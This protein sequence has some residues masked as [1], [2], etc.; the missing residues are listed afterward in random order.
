MIRKSTIEK[1]DT[2]NIVSM[3]VDQGLSISQICKDNKVSKD[4]VKK[5]LVYKGVTLKEI[6][7]TYNKDEALSLYNSGKIIEELAIKYNVTEKTI[8]KNLSLMGASVVDKRGMWDL[9]EHFFD[10]IDTEEKAYWLG[11]IFADGYVA[12]DRPT[13]AMNLQYADI[14]HMQKFCDL[15]HYSSEI[16]TQEKDNYITCR[17]KFDN[18][19]IYQNLISKGCVPQKSLILQFPNE[20]IFIS[21]D[22]YSKEELIRH[23]LRGY[24]DGDGCVTYSDKEHKYAEFNVIGTKDFLQ[25]MMRYLPCGEK[26]LYAKHNNGKTYQILLTNNV[27]YQCIDYLYKNSTMYLDRK[28]NRYLEFRRSYGKL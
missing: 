9:N 23:F 8:K 24:F 4:S 22:R 1:F 25:G 28:Y 5:Y 7:Q 17:M 11:F 15:L 21:S 6:R 20:D 13:F 18:R 14:S 27:A 19:N 16:R 10:V 26:T 2:L 3:Y 12:K